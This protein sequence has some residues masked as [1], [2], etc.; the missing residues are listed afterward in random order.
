MHSDFLFGAKGYLVLS[1]GLEQMFSHVRSHCILPKCQS[2]PCKVEHRRGGKGRHNTSS[3]FSSTI[4]TI[5]SSDTQ[6]HTLFAVCISRQL[7]GRGRC[8]GHATH[9]VSSSGVLLFNQDLPSLTVGWWRSARS[10]VSQLHGI[11]NNKGDKV[12]A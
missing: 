12:R 7:K 1:S 10:K 11:H 4:Q 6:I 9:S 2:S 3:S 5:A 8:A